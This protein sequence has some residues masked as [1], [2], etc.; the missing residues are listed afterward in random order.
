[1]LFAPRARRLNTSLRLGQQAL[2]SVLCTFGMLALPPRAG[3]GGGFGGGGGGGQ[4]GGALEVALL[5]A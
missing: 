3:G 2:L 1:M 5:G 4:A